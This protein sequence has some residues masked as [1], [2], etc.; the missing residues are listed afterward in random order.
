M[1]PGSSCLRLTPKRL[2]RTAETPRLHSGLLRLRIG[3]DQ[4]EKSVTL[5]QFGGA[6]LLAEVAVGAVGAL[7][8]EAGTEVERADIV[9]PMAVGAGL[10]GIGE[11]HGACTVGLK[12]HLDQGVRATLL[13]EVFLIMHEKPHEA[14]QQ[15]YRNP[16]NWKVSGGYQPQLV[17]QRLKKRE[18]DFGEEERKDYRP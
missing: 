17:V 8:F 3:I 10:V 18:D 12:Q 1:I 7:A 6:D 16:N 11:F 13:A 4:V 5:P 15:G 14:A 2:C 9:A